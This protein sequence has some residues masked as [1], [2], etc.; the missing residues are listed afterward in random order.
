ERAVVAER[1]EGEARLLGGVAHDAL[2]AR[3]AERL[4]SLAREA[5]AGADLRVT[6]IAPDGTVLGESHHDRRLMDDH[7]D[8]PEVA[9]ALQGRVGQAVRRSATTGE[10]LLYVAVPIAAVGSVTGVSRVAVPLETVESAVTRLA[11]TIFGAALLGALAAL[12]VAYLLGRGITRPLAELAAQAE[13]SDLRA[14]FDVRGAAEVEELAAALRRMA[15]EARS[16][17]EAA[18]AERDRLAA[19]LAELTDGILIAD[20]LD[21][22]QLAN[23]AAERILERRGLVGRRLAD[24]IRDHEILEAVAG[25]RHGHEAV[26]QVERAE[27]PRFLRAVV[28]PIEG[29]Q[30]LL[31]IQDLSTMRRL[32]TVR[33]DFVANVSHELRTPIASLKAMAETLEAGAIEDAGAA[34][35]FVHRMHREIDGLA[36]LV[37]ELLALARVESGQEALGAADVRP[38]DLLEQV[39]RRLAPLAERAGLTLEVSAADGLPAVRVDGEKIA[40]VLGNLVHNAVKFTPAGG[41]IRLGAEARDGA[42]AFLVSDTGVGIAHDDLDRVFERFYKS[43]RARAGGGT[44]LGLAIAKHIVQAHGGQISASSEGIGRGATFTFTVPVAV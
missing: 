9:S 40:Q 13:R 27:P 11:G 24:V 17:R 34:R 31:A 3:D 12:G 29:G 35:D 28:R 16:Q 25:A 32:E 26:A 33:R 41:R 4:D 18:E 19:L 2:R 6:F 42:V 22:V 30:L 36:Q 20:A 8:R 5:A 15:T 39:S 23:P 43:D 14:Q 10:E 21:R 37:A 7:S 38:A 1:L 44:G